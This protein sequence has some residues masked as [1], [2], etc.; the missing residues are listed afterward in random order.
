METKA[1]HGIFADL[2][3]ASRREMKDVPE[4]DRGTVQYVLDQRN[5]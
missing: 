2:I 4:Q 3:E 1:I 5:Q